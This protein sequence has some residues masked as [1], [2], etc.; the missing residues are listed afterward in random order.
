MEDPAVRE[1]FVEE[2]GYVVMYFMDVLNRYHISAE[3]FSN[4]YLKKLETNMNR[5]YVK[6]Y[7]ELK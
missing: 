6:Q 4:A 3:E 7:K 5:D 2:R 1:R